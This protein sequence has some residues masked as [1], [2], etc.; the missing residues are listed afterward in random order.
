LSREKRKKVIKT[1][2]TDFSSRCHTLVTMRLSDPDDAWRTVEEPFMRA[3]IIVAA[4]L[5]MTAGPLYA[6]DERA[7]VKVSG[8]VAVSPDVTSGDIVGEAGVRVAPNLFVYGNVGQ[9]HNLQPSLV[10]PAVDVTDALLSANGVDVTGTARTPAWYTMG[11]VRY[12]V[13]TH[14]V[15]PYVFGS[16]GFAHLMPTAEFTYNSG[17]LGDLTPVAGQDVTQQLV[18]LGEYT[19][20]SSSNAFMFS[21]GGGVE[22]PV[23]PRVTVDVGYRLSRVNA[24]TPLTAHSIIAGVGYRF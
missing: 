2:L 11:G 15:S 19:Q 17:T 6:E 4:A 16:A 9:F 1:A 12:V 7:Y 18:S 22:M 21:A 10:Q 23:A 13:P 14:G 5:L 20:P 8:G 3:L 24:D